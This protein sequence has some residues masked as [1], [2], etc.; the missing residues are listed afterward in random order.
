VCADGEYCIKCDRG[1]AATQSTS[2]TG[3]SVSG[4]AAT[5][6]SSQAGTS[7][8]TNGVEAASEHGYTFSQQQPLT[9]PDTAILLDNQSTVDLF[10]NDKLLTN[11]R[12]VPTWMVIKCNAGMN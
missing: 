6:S 4:A 8:V 1:A 9:I 12:T 3:A 5:S 11:I 7:L 10:R 2:Q